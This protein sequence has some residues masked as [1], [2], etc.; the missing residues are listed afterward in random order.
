MR[1]FKRYD[2]KNN[3]FFGKTDIFGKNEFVKLSLLDLLNMCILLV[4]FVPYKNGRHIYF[5]D[6]YKGI[7]IQKSKRLLTR[8]L[9]ISQKVSFSLTEFLLIILNVL[10]L[11]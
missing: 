9:H 2:N 5:V 11:F 8:V 10:Q 7:Y 6:K 1:N 4:Q 3:L